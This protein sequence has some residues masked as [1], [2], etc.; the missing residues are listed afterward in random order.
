MHKVPGV[1]TIQAYYK[2]LLDQVQSD[3]KGAAVAVGM[4]ASSNQAQGQVQD[5]G[6]G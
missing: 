5:L 1:S 4:G 6:Y 2:A 3:G